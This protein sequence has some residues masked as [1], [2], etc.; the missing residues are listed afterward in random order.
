MNRPAALRVGVFALVGTALLL[1][2]V[3]WVSRDWFGATET[4]RLRFA[5]SVY[6][7]QPGAPVVFRGVRVGHV[8]SV[9]LAADEPADEPAGVGTRSAGGPLAGAAL[10]VPVVAQV[11]RAALAPLLGG[12]DTGQPVLPRL[13]QAGLVARLQTQS[14]LTGLLYVD[15]DIDDGLR[16]AGHPARAAGP[17]AAGP[18]GDG[19]VEVPTRSAGLAAL[20][21]QLATVDLARV[22]ADL[23]AVAAGARRLLEQ[24]GADQALARAASAAAQLQSLAGQLERD[25]ARLARGA[26]GLL[27][28]GRQSLAMLSPAAGQAL[29][30]VTGAASAATAAAAVIERDAASTLAALGAAAGALEQGAASLAR[31]A[32]AEGPLAQDATR[33]LAEVNRA[34]RALR[35]LAEMLDRHPDAL[36]RGRAPGPDAVTRPEGR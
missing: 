18:G 19:A 23:A 12:A 11:E 6:G 1:A 31:L 22:G 9:A 27:A 13:V 25:A 24:P 21:A 3:L 8:L 10:S 14:L 17:A 7:L 35:E 32:D 30:A 16:A 20:Q 28:E 5:G 29:Q 26:D 36:L 34:A 33:A 15:L 2:A 4:M